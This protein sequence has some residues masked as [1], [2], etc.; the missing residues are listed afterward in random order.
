MHSRLVS[1]DRRLTSSLRQS[2]EVQRR[3]RVGFVMS[4]EVGLKTQY[5]NWR[6]SLEPELAIDPE[7]IVINWWNQEGLIERLPVVPGKV[8]SWLRSRIELRQGLKSGPFDA[9]YIANL[10]IM[11]GN[12]RALRAQPYFATSDSTMKLLQDFGDIYGMRRNSIPL[13]EWRRHSLLAEAYRGALALFPWSNWAAASLVDDY[14]VNPVRI[15]VIPP[16]VDIDRW[17]V[18][19]RDP[20]KRR[21]DILFVGGDF[22]RKGGDVVLDWAHRTSARNWMLHLVTR[23]RM[24]SPLPQVAAEEGEDP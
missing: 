1:S 21:V 11:R 24:S 23:E 18:P 19:S 22:Y 5:L 3:L 8:K 16:G 17:R 12:K 4:T 13:Y 14:G 15:H 2:P 10:K 6:A 7:W 20:N 9:L